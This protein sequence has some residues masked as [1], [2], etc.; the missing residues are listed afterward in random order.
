MFF[1]DFV[2]KRPYPKTMKILQREPNSRLCLK[3]RFLLGSRS[4]DVLKPTCPGS[5]MSFSERIVELIVLGA[6]GKGLFNQGAH[7]V[8]LGFLRFSHRV[9]RLLP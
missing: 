5:G 3:S 2:N 1:L 4:L 7:A 6:P 8:R 9:L